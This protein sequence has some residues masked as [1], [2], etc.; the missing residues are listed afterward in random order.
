[1]NFE[2]DVLNADALQQARYHQYF[3]LQNSLF[4]SCKSGD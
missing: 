1:M 4:K 2:F 3:E